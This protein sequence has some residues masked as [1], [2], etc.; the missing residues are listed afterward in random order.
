M[1]TVGIRV[2]TRKIREFSTFGVSSALRHSQCCSESVLQ[3][4]YVDF[5]TLWTFWKL[6][7]L[8]FCFNLILFCCFLLVY[9]LLVLHIFISVCMLQALCC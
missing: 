5:W 7:R 9:F 1:D 6:S 3:M 2:P 4:T 8:S